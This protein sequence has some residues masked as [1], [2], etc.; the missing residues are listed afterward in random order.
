[1]YNEKDVCEKCAVEVNAFLKDYCEET[2]NFAEAILFDDGSTDGTKDIVDAAVKD[3]NLEYITVSGH[4]ENRGKG[5]AVREAVL[6]SDGDVTVYTDCDLAYGVSPVKTAVDTLHKT[7]ADIV[8]GTRNTG[9]GSYGEY[10]FIRRLASKVYIKVISIAAGFKHSDSQC[11]F[12]VF[13]G[14]VARKVFSLCSVD[15]FSFDLEALLIA[16][17]AG[18]TIAEMPITIVNHRESKIH[19][20]RDAIKM[21]RDVCRIKKSVKKRS[22]SIKKIAK[23]IDNE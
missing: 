23:S 2:G 20:A 15:G 22:D 19:V 21:L 16:E 5:S 11:G 4:S 13:R 12:K 3:K 1:M 7:G 17:A 8:I 9:G 18:Y 14:D 6:L 10:T